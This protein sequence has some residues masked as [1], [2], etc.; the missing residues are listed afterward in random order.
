MKVVFAR[1]GDGVKD[2][3]KEAMM[4]VAVTPNYGG[5]QQSTLATFVDLVPILN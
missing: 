2:A 4:K 5:P 1:H 3:V